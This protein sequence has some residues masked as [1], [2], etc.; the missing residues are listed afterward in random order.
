MNDPAILF[1]KPKAISGRDKK[2]LQAAGVY[3]IEIADPSNA[4]FVR[5][6]AELSSTEM[7]HAAAKAIAENDYSGYSEKAFGN[8]ICAAIIAK[9]GIP[10]KGESGT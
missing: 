2:A 3:V 10:T 8:A 4:K 5:A 6:G 9:Y 1:V 7:L